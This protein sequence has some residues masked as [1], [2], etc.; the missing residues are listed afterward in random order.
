VKADYECVVHSEMG[1]E[2]SSWNAYT[3]DIEIEMCYLLLGDYSRNELLQAQPQAQA[4]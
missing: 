2:L 3:E 1:S 4:L